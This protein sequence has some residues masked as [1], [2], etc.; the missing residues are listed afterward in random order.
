[1]FVKMKKMYKCLAIKIFKSK[2]K[3]RIRKIT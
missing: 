1:M 2:N 3:V